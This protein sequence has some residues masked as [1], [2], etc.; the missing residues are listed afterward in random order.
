MGVGELLCVGGVEPRGLVGVGVVR[1]GVV[2]GGLGVGG[3]VLKGSR[4]TS[5]CDLDFWVL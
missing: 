4:E 5:V 3:L 1:G 2:A